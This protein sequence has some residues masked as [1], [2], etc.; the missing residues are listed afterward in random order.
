[1]KTPD[2]TTTILV[3]QTPEE[4]F[5]AINNVRGWWS[6]NIRGNTDKL[7]SE[8][9]NQ[10]KDI[11]RCKMKIVELIPAQKVV[12]MVTDN[13]FNFVKDKSEWIGTKVIFN[14][15]RKENKTEIRFTHL[16]LVPQYE[17]YEICFEAWSNYIQNSLHRL[18]TTGKGQPTPKEI[19]KESFDIQL[20]EK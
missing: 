6:E 17:C 3:D 14:I 19:K 1:M 12:W 8:F 18:I 5:D 7:N 11:H 4:A 16:G 10:Y 20:A 2:F 9:T 15:V 13:Y